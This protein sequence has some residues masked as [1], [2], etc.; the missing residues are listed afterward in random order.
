[1]IGI[2]IGAHGGL[3]RE[4][5][6]TAEHVVGPQP[7]VETVSIQPDDDRSEKRNLICEAAERVDWSG[8]GYS[9]VFAAEGAIYCYQ[10]IYR[11]YFQ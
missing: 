7:A 11:K 10:N 4:F 5:L 9:F 1:M 6:A 8:C 3:A 2:G